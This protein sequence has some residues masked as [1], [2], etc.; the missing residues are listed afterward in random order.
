M[1]GVKYNC[2][3]QYM[4]A[5]KAKLFHDDESLAK[6]MAATSPKVQ[7]ALGRKV[8]NFD[9]AQWEFW[10]RSKVFDGNYAKFTQNPDL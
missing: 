6:I 5:Q 3:E 7:K 2:T 10:G 9:A 1:G 4:M 8:K